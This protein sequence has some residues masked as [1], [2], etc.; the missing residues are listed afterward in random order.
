MLIQQSSIFFQ[1]SLF[2]LSTQTWIYLQVSVSHVLLETFGD[3]EARALQTDP[4]HSS[5]LVALS[6]HKR[7][8]VELVE[9]N[10]F[11]LW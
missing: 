10:C 2:K 1:V 9:R 3:A 7:S 5:N 11:F 8:V 4:K 6:F